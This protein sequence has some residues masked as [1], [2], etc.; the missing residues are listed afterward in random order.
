MEKEQK[1]DHTDSFET[2]FSLTSANKYVP[3][4]IYLDLE[5]T[6]IGR[7]RSSTKQLVTFMSAHI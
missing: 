5:P 1:E 3:R 6:V 4:A 7:N 2:F